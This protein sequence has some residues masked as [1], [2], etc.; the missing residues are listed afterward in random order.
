MAAAIPEG[1][2]EGLM[3]VR[4]TGQTNMFARNAVADLAESMGHDDTA[5][6]MRDKANSEAYVAWLCCKQ[7]GAD[8]E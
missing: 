5:D 7:C 2:I 8:R 4:E 6:W 1:A 3:A